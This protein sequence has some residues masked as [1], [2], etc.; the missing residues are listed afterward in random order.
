MFDRKP[1]RNDVQDEILRRIVAGELA[2]GQ[3]LN[4]S[5]LAAELAIS[6]TPLREALIGLQ[7]RG[8]LT[9]ALG[10]GFQVPPLSRRAIGE[11]LGLLAMLEPEALRLAGRP[12]PASQVELGN[13]ISR[14][15]LDRETTVSW[16]HRFH[17]LLLRPCPSA[18]LRILAVHLNQQTLRYFTAA[19]AGGW[20]P[21]ATWNELTAIGEELR[22][23]DI[24]AAATRLRQLRH[25]Q[26][27]ALGAFLEPPQAQAQNEAPDLAPDP[28]PDGDA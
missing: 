10:R 25:D 20:D 13:A 15:R 1:L 3:R 7:Q 14:G 18:Q 11:T 8:F 23:V 5:H 21:T 17:T 24:D 16:L 2:A 26:P 19:L 6:R 22:S 27:A 28:T 4:E 9:S 12:A